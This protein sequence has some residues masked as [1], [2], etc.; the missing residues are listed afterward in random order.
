MGTKHLE[1]IVLGSV[2]RTG[3]VARLGPAKIDSQPE[4]ETAK[5]N[6]AEVSFDF[7]RKISIVSAF[8]FR[9]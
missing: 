7:F 8:I 3:W 4:T 6:I 1:A 2:V 5:S 9:W